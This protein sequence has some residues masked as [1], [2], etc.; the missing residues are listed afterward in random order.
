MITSNKT[1][2]LEQNLIARAQLANVYGK[3]ILSPDVVHLLYSS[4][5]TTSCTIFYIYYTKLQQV[6]AI[7]PGHLQGVTIMVD[8]HNGYGSSDSPSAKS[9]GV[10]LVSAKQEINQ[11]NDK[12]RE[13]KINHK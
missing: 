4:L 7:Y 5:S 2:L 6:S 3:R 12:G 9:K 8:V 13:R 10:R 1:V 11:T